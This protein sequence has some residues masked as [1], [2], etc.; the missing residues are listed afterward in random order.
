MKDL[1]GGLGYV[2]M[3]DVICLLTTRVIPSFDSLRTRSLD[4]SCDVLWLLT[5]KCLGTC[6]ILLYRFIPLLLLFVD[7]PGLL[8]EFVFLFVAKYIK[9]TTM[10]K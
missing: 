7:L 4:I 1:I 2:Y 9:L 6:A 5:P 10:W 8:F 3:N